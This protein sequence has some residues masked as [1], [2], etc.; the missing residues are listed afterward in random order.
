MPQYVW[1]QNHSY[2]HTHNG[3]WEKYR[4]PYTTMSINEYARPE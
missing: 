3:N 2:H 1:S 4:G